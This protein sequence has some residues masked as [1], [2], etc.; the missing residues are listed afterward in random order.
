MLPQNV[1]YEWF[2]K[3]DTKTPSLRGLCGPILWREHFVERTMHFV[4]IQWFQANSMPSVIHIRLVARCSDS[5][6]RHA[7]LHKN[8]KF[9]TLHKMRSTNSSTIQNTKNP[10]LRGFCGTHK[11][12][13]STNCGKISVFCG[14]SIDFQRKPRF[15]WF[16]IFH[17]LPQYRST[18]YSRIKTIWSHSFFIS[19]LKIIKNSFAD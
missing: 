14:K 10:P 11:L 16:C 17:W 5:T 9:H 19:V 18:K 6:N 4:E 1:L 7:D 12:R 13:T 2:H 15:L 3:W 8:H